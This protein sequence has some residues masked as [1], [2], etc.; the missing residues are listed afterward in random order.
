MIE[1]EHE[2]EHETVLLQMSPLAGS[3]P[4]GALGGETNSRC[5]RVLGHVPGPAQDRAGLRTPQQHTR[6]L[7]NG[8]QFRGR[9]RA[10]P[11]RRSTG[12][13]AQ[14]NLRAGRPRPGR[15]DDQRYEEGAYPEM[16]FLWT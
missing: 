2:N 14:D 6:V 13:L 9:A 3:L 16:F 11:G 5:R 10:G 4:E 7:Q 1:H 12:D 8:G 15:F